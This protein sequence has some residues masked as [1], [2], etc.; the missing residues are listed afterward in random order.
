MERGTR[1]ATGRNWPDGR[2]CSPRARSLLCVVIVRIRRIRARSA[3]LVFLVLY[4]VVGLLVGA[5]VA[6]VSSMDLPAGAQP[7][8][9]NRLG[10]WSLLIFPAGYG[11]L[12]GI[13]AGI[14]ATLYNAAAALVGGIKVEIPDIEPVWPDTERG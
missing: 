10:M 7:N 6:V 12:A 14:S 4:G 8:I 9:L 11:L 5:V 1:G 3:F 2:D 13:V